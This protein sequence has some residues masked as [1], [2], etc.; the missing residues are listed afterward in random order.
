MSARSFKRAHA[1]RIA[2]ERR[3]ARVLGRKGTQIAGLA[4]TT[5]TLFAAN[6]YAATNTY[7]VTTTGD[8]PSAAACTAQ[9]TAGTYDCNT[10]RDA[11]GAVN[12]TSNASTIDFAS[13]VTGVIRLTSGVLTVDADN[14][15]TIT[16]PG[17]GTLAISGDANNDGKA[18]SGDSQIFDFIAPNGFTNTVSGLTLTDGYASGTSNGGAID[19]DTTSP[20]STTDPLELVDDKI[21]DSTA[22]GTG[23]GGAVFGYGKL[24]VTGSTIT[25]NTAAGGTGGGIAMDGKSELTLTNSTVSGNA[26]ATSGGGIWAAGKYGLAIS[27][28]SISGNTS[29]RGGGIEVAPVAGKYETRPV[30]P[31]TVTDSTVSGNNATDGA[32]IEMSREISSGN[33][34]E[35][36]SSTI[37]GNTGGAS[38]DGGGVLLDDGLYGKFKLVDSTV[39]GNSATTGGGL[40]VGVSTAPLE[41]T[42]DGTAGSVELE[43]S[44][45]AGNSATSGTGGGGIYLPE[46]S[47]GTPATNQSPTVSLSSTIVSG[48][49][50]AGVAQ[51]VF[52]PPAST[53][54][55]FD[56]AFSLIQTP[57]GAPMLS[58]Q[59]D[60]LGKSP[61]LGP[62][63]NNGGTTET[64]LPS[65]TSP[66]I[67]QGHAPN[68]LTTDERGDPRTVEIPGIPRPP[69]G[70]GTDI[71]AVEL[72]AS[73]VP[74]VLQ[75]TLRGTLLSSAVSPLLPGT[76]SPIDC[77]VRIGTLN[78]CVIH[79]ASGGKLLADGDAQSPT[80][81]TTLAVS[82]TPT[83]AGLKAITKSPTGITA[84][85]T[86]ATGGN[87]GAQ[88]TSGNVHLLAGP[89]FT[90]QTGK[91]DT[92]TPSKT[93]KGELKQ[94]AELLQG[95][96]AKSVTCTAYTKK[97]PHKGKNDKSDTT[98]LAK[99][100]CG[101]VLV[102]GFKGK[103]KVAGKGHTI[104]ANEVV[105]S[106]AL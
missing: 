44:T 54:G 68:S 79:V 40:A 11:V 59:S 80:G 97:G 91:T 98:A 51:D 71:G 104:A 38:S 64:M 18:D 8:D 33:E 45:I 25:G 93:V 88:S 24:T 16:G 34:M 49:T 47:N 61:D 86:I 9:A 28:S 76:A 19:D 72:S 35:I 21:T 3:R 53:T 83:A 6:A 31:V 95:A 78:S 37:S 100:V 4:L 96:R 14:A 85:A 20:D 23:D 90:L 66:V 42:Y 50:A 67:D 92:K 60:I 57:A 105:I 7:T 46:Y 39:S 101:Y 41:G 30:N 58:E 13:G 15:L 70:D 94:V 75:A 87:G 89:L 22:A 10:L 2:R 12:S 106:F 74:T 52:R 65:G 56:S 43:N 73:S 77:T 62:L 36:E 1:R 82:L 102:D 17:A 84:P 81:A 69:G 63:G 103:T 5:G 48:N 27:G 99:N 55:G 32:G 26:G 29:V